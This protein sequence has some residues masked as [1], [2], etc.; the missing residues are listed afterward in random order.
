MEKC[1]YCDNTLKKVHFNTPRDCKCVI[2]NSCIYKIKK[3]LPVCPF[4]STS[5]KNNY[6]YPVINLIS[7]QISSSKKKQ[8]NELERFHSFL[9][10]AYTYKESS[11][12]SKAVDEKIS[13]LKSLRSME[14]YDY[15]ISTLKKFVA[16]IRLPETKEKFF[17]FLYNFLER[18]TSRYQH[19]CLGGRKLI[20]ESL[21]QNLNLILSKSTEK[22]FY[23]QAFGV[24]LPDSRIFK[25]RLIRLN[26]KVN[27]NIVH[28]ENFENRFP[29][30]NFPSVEVTIDNAIFIDMNMKKFEIEFVIEQ[31][32]FILLE[33][34]D[35]FTDS[36][37]NL[38]LQI[39]GKVDK[40]MLAYIKYYY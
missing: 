12:A 5:L 15:E 4:C 7:Y 1:S 16:D 10:Q 37:G 28:C 18:T 24:I 14:L 40:S 27:E 38:M 30:F 32:H 23:I 8:I 22:N 33:H 3:N 35:Y 20:F 29:D 39:A 2:C 13:L 11:I 21:N 26:V 9:N 19:A 34:D 31:G 36:E 25:A 17:T 6:N